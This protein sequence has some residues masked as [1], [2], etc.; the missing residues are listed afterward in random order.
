VTD[1]EKELDRKFNEYY[2][3]HLTYP[4]SISLSY[5]FD[6]EIYSIAS[7]TPTYTMTGDS[8][9]TWRG[10]KVKYVHRKNYIEM[11]PR[12]RKP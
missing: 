10:C 2:Q 9:F 11:I 4:Q 5:E 6:R 7:V 12:K 1:F 3:R 8:F